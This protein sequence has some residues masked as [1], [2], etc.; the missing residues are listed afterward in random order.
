[1]RSCLLT[2][3]A[4]ADSQRL[5]SWPW[6]WMQPD[7]TKKSPPV[8]ASSAIG[9]NKAPI[10]IEGVERIDALFAIER[11]IN[12]MT[13]QQRVHVRTARSRPLGSTCM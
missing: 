1:M 3:E 10:G 6:G 8:S 12:G 7:Q 11:E 13:L 9:I 5:F 2:G 4:S